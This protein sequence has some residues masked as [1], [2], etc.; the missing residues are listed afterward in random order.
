MAMDVA[1]R[2]W[3]VFVAIIGSLYAVRHLFFSW[4]RLWMP[5]RTALH[6]L[7]D[8]TPPP[9]TVLV[10]MHNEEKV[11]ARILELLAGTDYPHELLQV[12][13]INDHSEDGTAEIVNAYA[14]RFPFIQALHIKQGA[15]GKAAGLNRALILAKHEIVLVFDA[16][17]EPAPGLLRSLAAVFLDSTIGACMGRVVPVNTG[18][19]LLTRLLSLERTGGYQVDQ[20]ARFNLGLLPQY[21]GTVGGFRRSVV[22]ELGGFDPSAVSEDTDLTIRLYIA[23]WGVAYVNRAECYEEVPETWSVRFRQLRRWSR[24]HNTALIKT[25]VALMRSKRSWR[26]KYDAFLL[27]GEFAMPPLILSAAAANVVL[28]LQGSVLAWQEVALALSVVLYN[29][30]GSFAPFYQIAAGELLDGAGRRL[31]LIP[32]MALAF[33]FNCW[34]VTTGAFDAWGDV[35]K[36]RIPIWEKTER[37]A[38]T[39]TAENVGVA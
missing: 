10:P 25:S 4:N 19:N 20:Q 14:R 23:G 8:R 5:Q 18:R 38:T 32:F 31:M 27:M 30:F 22:M 1:L 11:A 12:I 26:E 24:G 21:G 36:Q 2:I 34:C 33:P 28:F 13:A 6:E 17:Y 16:D 29:A 15:R 9:V 3:V 35:L 37:F 39:E 7:Q